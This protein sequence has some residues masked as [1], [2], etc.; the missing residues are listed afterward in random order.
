MFFEF[1]K[2]F[3]KCMYAFCFSDYGK[4]KSDD[5]E[6]DALESDTF[7]IHVQQSLEKALMDD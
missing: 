4:I 7:Y 5:E 1:V 3:F 2:S 6:K